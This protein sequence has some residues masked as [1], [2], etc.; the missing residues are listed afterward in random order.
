M[1]KL[2]VLNI[3]LNKAQNPVYFAGEILAGTVLMRVLEPIKINWL[4]LSV[5]GRA[6][7]HW[8]KQDFILKLSSRAKIMKITYRIEMHGIGESKRN[9]SYSTHEKYLDYEKLL[10]TKES[11]DEVYINVGDYEFPF[12]V[13]LPPFLPSR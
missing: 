13:Q 10:I 2:A 4:K 7:V 6:Q 11:S 12:Q 5:F 1:G 9:E 3:V 8:Y